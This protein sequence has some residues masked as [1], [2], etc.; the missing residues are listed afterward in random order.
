MPTLTQDFTQP[1]DPRLAPFLIHGGM[2]ERTPDGLRLVAPPAQRGVYVNAQLDDYRPYRRRRDYPW[3]PP[4]T[5]TVRMRTSHPAGQMGGTYGVGFWNN[6]LTL[7]GG[8]IL[9]APSATWFF[10]GSPPHNL[11]LAEGIP[12]HGW[13]AQNLDAG[14]W[15]GLVFAPM[16]AVGVTLCQVPG[17]GRPLMRIARRILGAR[18]ALLPDPT[19]WHDYRLVW[20]ADGVRFFVD[21]AEVLRSES[22]PRGPLGLV[23]WV[24][25]QF[26]V[27]SETGKFQFGVIEHSAPRWLELADLR[28][29]SE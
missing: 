3:S 17:L 28:I 11:Y 14:R 21:D 27:A 4:L 20:R 19:D 10:G 6:P 2:H 7:T 29:E 9:A 15:P 8:G 5:L 18:E 24:D 1:L 22:A 25:N 13:K 12:G 26:A 16:A 23:I